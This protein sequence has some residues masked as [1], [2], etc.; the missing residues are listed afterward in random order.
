M[1]VSVYHP[2]ELT[3]ADRAAWTALQS[4]A[5]PGGRPQMA[6]PF[7]SPEFTLAV[8]RC[9]RGVRVAVVREKGPS[10]EPV[11]FFPYQRYPAGV[12]RAVAFGMSDC[13]GLVH[14]PGFEWDADELLA[15]CGLTLWEFDHLTAGQHPFEQ[16]ATGSFASPVIDVA[17]GWDAYLA[18]LRAKSPT[19]TGTTLAKERKLGRHHTDVRYVHDERDPAVLRTLMEWKSAQYHRTGL[20]DR[21][22]RP[23]ITQLVQQLFQTRSEPFAGIL[24][25]L[26][27][28]GRPIAAHF[29]LRTERVLA[30]WFPAYDPAFAKYSPGLIHIMHMVQA[31][32]RDGIA[33][34]D[35]GRGDS[36]YKD[37]FKTDELSV[38]EGL[39]SRR[40]PVAL[41]LGKSHAPVRAL[42][43]VVFSHA[44]VLGRAN[45][46]LRSV[47]MPRGPGKAP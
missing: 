1:D 3:A 12:G 31:A 16:S 2:D 33:Y 11:A 21:F 41:V 28:D 26:Y 14:R 30:V 19:F 43:D 42:A 6:N 20:A 23:W 32:A 22:A 46:L 24:S 15:A 29:G 37:S 9:K 4:A 5:Q 13:Q 18:R 47:G 10:G 45:R 38:S 7:L 17:E 8:G 27:A 34:L 40:H 25:V 36:R 35:L 39:V 44:E